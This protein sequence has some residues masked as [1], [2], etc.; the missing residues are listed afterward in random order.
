MEL[1][2]F[3]EE[4]EHLGWIHKLMDP[5]CPLMTFGLRDGYE[6]WVPGKG[7][8]GGNDLKRPCQPRFL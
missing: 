7:K 5:K 1:K 4:E 2:F 8:G 6:D 3:T